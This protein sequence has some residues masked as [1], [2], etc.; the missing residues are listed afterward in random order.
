MRESICVRLCMM[1]DLAPFGPVWSVWSAT[2]GH[3]MM[4]RSPNTAA[5]IDIR[6]VDGV[7]DMKI[8]FNP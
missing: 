7:P 3:P 8:K 6:G 5:T 1:Q 4:S 2:F